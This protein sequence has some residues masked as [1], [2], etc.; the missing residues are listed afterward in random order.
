[1]M[2][3]WGARMRTLF[4]RI[5]FRRVV[6]AGLLAAVM[7]M[8]S[9]CAKSKPKP[10]TLW[11]GLNTHL[12]HS[13]YDGQWPSAK[14]SAVDRDIY[15]NLIKQLGVSAIRDLFMSWARVQSQP[16]A[17]YDFTLSDDLMRR[18]QDAGVDILAL[19]WGVP[20]WAASGPGQ[21]SVD[22]GLP[23]SQHRD[24]FIAFVRAFVE[25]Y[26]MDGKDDMPELRQPIRAYEFMSEVESIPVD[27]YSHWLRLFYVTVKEA[28]PNATVSV[29]GLRSPGLRTINESSGDYH[30]YFEELLASPELEGSGYPYFDVVSFHSYPEHYPGR[31]AFDDA[32]AYL[33]T[34]MA[35]HDL[36]LPIWLTEFGY[37][38][39]AS[40]EARQADQIV[41]WAIRARS[42]GID[43]V[44]LY[45]L[46][47]Y[48][49]PG[50][51]RTDQNMG[52]VREVESGKLP[53]R[54][55]AFHAYAGLIR[56][57]R[58]RPNVDF[59]GNGWYALTGKGE[60]VFAVWRVE[61]Y[62]PREALMPD[63]WQVRT[64]SGKITVRQGTDI[65]LTSSPIFI[66]RTPSPFIE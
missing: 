62:N 49:W 52:L 39:G 32:L 48:H 5:V 54:K 28:D 58:Q 10:P 55:P 59:R 63:W 43:R 26:D 12:G 45:C 42:L 8:A 47:D 61:S 7:L 2:L 23:S 14:T 36:R 25:R 27:E 57:L 64:L 38:S 11:V 29:A 33:R 65:R 44:Y 31:T 17:P 20:R 9:G 53:P 37:N 35:Q 24:A 13:D 56:E 51:S 18:A 19:C 4:G 21:L 50:G 66:E 15:F 34:T 40:G 6:A 46:W 60:P 16:D 22:F 41:K 30:K 1:M 3:M